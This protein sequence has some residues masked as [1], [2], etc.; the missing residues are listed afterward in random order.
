MNSMLTKIIEDRA[1]EILKNFV[2]AVRS[3]NHYRR[4]TPEEVYL[5]GQ[6]F[7]EAFVGSVR[8]NKLNIF[9][10][11]IHKVVGERAVQGYGLDEILM[12]FQV[13]EESIWL[14]VVEKSSPS[15]IPHL[16]KVSNT[17]FGRGKD[18]V[19]KVYLNLRI[20]AEKKLHRAYGKLK[21][22]QAQL[23]QSE[24]MA[25]LGQLV[26]GIAHELNNPINF[27]YSNMDHL[28]DYVNRIK[29]MLAVYDQ[30]RY[31]DPEEAD[32]ILRSREE[33][34]IDFILEDL[35]KLIRAFYDGAERTKGIVLNLKSFSRLDGEDP[36]KVDIH[37]CIENTLGLLT[38][39]YKHRIRL[40]KAYGNVP[41][42]EGYVGHLNQ[43]FMNLFT[44]AG[45]AVEGE[46]DVW[47]TTRAKADKV[48]VTIRDN[49]KGIPKENLS[50]IFDPF[51]TTKGVG[52]GTGLGLSITY[53]IIEKHKGKIFVDSQVGTGTTFTVELPVA[54]A[55]SREKTNEEGHGPQKAQHPDR[56]RRRAQ[57]GH[58]TEDF[59]EE[60]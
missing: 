52:E 41:P 37:E 39:I 16:L 28:E 50:K 11:Y 21:S 12:V 32:F 45:Q 47:I 19:A 18:E 49:G 1:E 22:T 14:A 4:L 59:Q 34:E 55:R 8:E 38:N 31:C 43:V 24:K 53:S 23:I 33:L 7:L 17:I 30:A 54:S 9:L 27:I 42:I 44:N 3:F 46:G 26:A 57:S 5:R 13:L 29:K 56:R 36:A 48:L 51:F 58:L 15:E 6:A 25:S 60:V 35:D 2:Q 20:R 40:H 10:S